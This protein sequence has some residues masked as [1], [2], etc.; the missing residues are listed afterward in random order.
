MKL[1]KY[2]G[3]GIEPVFI[4]RSR[5]FA[6]FF[7]VSIVSHKITQ[8]DKALE[9]GFKLGP[10]FSSGS[11]DVEIGFIQLGRQDGLILQP[12]ARTL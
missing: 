4:L 9:F 11:K 5:I 6:L 2:N 10:R 8:S 3:F 12:F 1:R 7:F